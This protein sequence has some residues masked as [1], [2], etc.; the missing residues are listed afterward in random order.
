MQMSMSEVLNPCVKDTCAGMN[1]APRSE[2]ESMAVLSEKNAAS[3]DDR[4]T[5]VVSTG[6]SGVPIE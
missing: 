2:E 6:L 3:L 5:L 1:T 4:H